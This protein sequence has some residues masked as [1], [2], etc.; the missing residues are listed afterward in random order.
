M[1]QGFRFSPPREFVASTSPSASYSHYQFDM[2]GFLGILFSS[3]LALLL[4]AAL[5]WRKTVQG[6]DAC[7]LSNVL[8]LRGPQLD[9]L[10]RLGSL[11][12]A[13]TGFAH[14]VEP[15]GDDDTTLSETQWLFAS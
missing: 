3:P 11:Y 7:C 6:W 9:M 8:Q 14:G 4:V 5:I 13:V 2:C 12:E 15:P 1:Y 10:H